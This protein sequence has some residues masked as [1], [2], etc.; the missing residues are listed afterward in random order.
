[1]AGTRPATELAA[2]PA[3]HN[4]PAP[5]AGYT[6][7][8]SGSPAI[9]RCALSNS[10]AANARFA[11]SPSRSG[12][13][14]DPGIIKSPVN[15]PS[16]SGLS[17]RLLCAVPLNEALQ[18]ERSE[19]HLVLPNLPSELDGLSIAHIS[20][21]HFTGR[22]PRR[23]F[24]EAVALVNQME[25][26]LIAITGDIAEYEHSL[27]WV[28]PVLGALRAQPTPGIDIGETY[29][30]KAK[31][32][33]LEAEEEVSLA[34]QTAALVLRAAG[35]VETYADRIVSRAESVHKIIGRILRLN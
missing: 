29:A 26:D 19:K 31:R 3:P 15:I 5:C 23:Y 35:E 11:A 4:D 33:S 34:A 2:I 17:A 12:L 13:P 25:P 20:D 9:F 30:I 22:V 1:M 21:L 14:S 27:P 7:T 28:Q 32:V 10:F 8:P 24:D 18:L 6:S 16:G